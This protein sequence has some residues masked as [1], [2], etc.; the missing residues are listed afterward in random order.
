MRRPLALSLVLAALST[1]S[2]GSAQA[3][4]MRCGR[5]LVSEGDLLYEVRERCGDPDATSQRVEY[6]TVRAY[7]AGA[8]Y[9]EQGQVR[10]GRMVE[11]T[12]EVVI[13]EWVYD[14]GEHK[15]VRYLTFEQGRLAHVRTGHYGSKDS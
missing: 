2:A 7:E 9:Q 14:R 15:F 1:W 13:D 8:C 4:G 11:R 10:C 3:D 12:I 5:R 6:R